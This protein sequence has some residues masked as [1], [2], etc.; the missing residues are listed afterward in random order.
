MLPVKQYVIDASGYQG[1][2]DFKKVKAA[3]IT[4][5]LLKCT[6]GDSYLAPKFLPNYKKALDAGLRVGAYHFLRAASASEGVREGE[7]FG[8]CIEGLTLELGA[9]LDVEHEGVNWDGAKVTPTD[10]CNI[11]SAFAQGAA[12]HDRPQLYEE[13]EMLLYASIDY[14]KRF[15]SSP[16]LRAYPT[17]LA[18]PGKL[19]YEGAV[20]LVQYSWS[21]RVDGVENEVDLNTLY[22]CAQK[23][24][25]TTLNDAPTVFPNGD[26]PVPP[27]PIRWH[28]SG[29]IGCRCIDLTIEQ[30]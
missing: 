6:E 9:A 17:W 14:F 21:G 30:Q 27:D 5:V 10:A 20:K 26:V 12:K 22:P 1:E 11:V 2:I 29:T 18:N 15:L 16:A 7:W 25:M 23:V 3:G 4:G 24:E 13:K 28:I 19:P 8:K